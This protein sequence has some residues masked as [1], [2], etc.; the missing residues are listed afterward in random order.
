MA[1]KAWPKGTKV[2]VLR[3]GRVLP[4]DLPCRNHQGVWHQNCWEYWKETMDHGTPQ[5]Q[6][7]LRYQATGKRVKK[8]ERHVRV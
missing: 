2:C 8:G 7:R 3:D 4:D 6:S 5:S 1:G